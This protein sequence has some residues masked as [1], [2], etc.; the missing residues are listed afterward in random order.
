MT[1]SLTVRTGNL[2]IIYGPM[3]CDSHHRGDSKYGGKTGLM[4]DM[5]RAIKLETNSKAVVIKPSLD[6]R[7]S[8][9]FLRTADGDFVTCN[10][11]C[12]DDLAS[13][14]RS[15]RAEFVFVT[16]GHMWDL[17]KLMKAVSEFKERGLCVAVDGIDIDHLRRPFPWVPALSQI[18]DSIVSLDGRCWCGS[19]SMHTFRHL[20][21]DSAVK[22]GDLGDYE[23]MCEDCFRI[24]LKYKRQREIDAIRRRSLK[25][26]TRRVTHA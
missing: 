12:D 1:G 24:A 18:A 10:Q 13:F 5:F 17:A 19:R 20:M 23:P 3:R 21:D 2:T 22:A 16:E 11:V 26:E 4:I 6:T 9:N 8:P 25:Q 7:D 14:V 15:S